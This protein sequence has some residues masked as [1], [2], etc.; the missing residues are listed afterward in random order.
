MEKNW[1]VRSRQS[2]RQQPVVPLAA[3]RGFAWFDAEGRIILSQQDEVCS[4]SKQVY[5]QFLWLDISV[6]T[7]YPVGLRIEY[8]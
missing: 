2:E 3:F 1:L 8:L 4:H 6:A 7:S 5:Y